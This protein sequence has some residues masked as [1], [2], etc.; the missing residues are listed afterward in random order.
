MTQALVALEHLRN[1]VDFNSWED[2]LDVLDEDFGQVCSWNEEIDESRWS[3]HTRT[4]FQ[5]SDSS[6]M[7]IEWERGLTEM[8][9]SFGPTDAYLVEPYEETVTRYRRIDG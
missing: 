8:Q 5:F 3:M 7:A 1:Q 4:I 9:E 2:N 6:L